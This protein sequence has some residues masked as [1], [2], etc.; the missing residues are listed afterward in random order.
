M[1]ERD[2][3]LDVLTTVGTIG[4]PRCARTQRRSR[5]PARV[6]GAA[7]GS[8]RV[9]ELQRR[10]YAIVPYVPPAHVERKRKRASSALH[11]VLKVWGAELIHEEWWVHVAWA[12][13]A[14]DDPSRVPVAWLSPDL[15][16]EVIK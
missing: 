14:P 8:G 10:A 12:D 9:L 2:A 7:A 16:E 1:A 5:Q 6:S 4:G 13:P 3:E 15:Q 11:A